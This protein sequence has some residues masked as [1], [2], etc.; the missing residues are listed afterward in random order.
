MLVKDPNCYN[1]VNGGVVGTTNMV[2]VK[3][4]DGNR[5]SNTEAYNNQPS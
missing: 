2:V 3:D 1:I 4:K 5:F